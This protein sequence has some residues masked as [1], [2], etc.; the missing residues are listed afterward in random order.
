VPD[1]AFTDLL[2]ITA[3]AAGVPL[4]LGWAPRLR[5]PSVVLEIVAGI[6][7][8]PSVLGWVRVD[9]PVQILALVG[10][11][12][13]L[14][15]AGLEIDVRGI[16]GRLLRLAGAGYV[17]SAGLAVLVGFGFRSLG[18]T[19]SPLLLAVA[20]TATSLGLVVPVLKDAGKIGDP[21]GQATIAA[22]S[23]A[24]FTAIVL[25]TLLFSTSGG[26]AGTT[27]LFL[28]VFGVLVA[29]LAL[30]L[31]RVGRSMRLGEVLV[32]L[33]DSTA[34]IR[35]RLVVLLLAAFVALAER[36]GLET[37]LGAFLA[38]A[39]VGLVDRDSATH[40]RFRAKLDAIGYGFLIP[41]FFVSSGVG[42]DLRG[43]FE[44]PSALI[45]VPVFL[46][47]LLVVRGVP[48]M[49]FVRSL[50][51]RGATAVGLLQATSL[52]FL[53]TVA[54]IGTATGRLSGTNAAA[55]VCAGLLSVLIFP[56]VS[57][58]LLGRSGRPA[59]P[60]QWSAPAAEIPAARSV[61]V[62]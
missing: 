9:L 12:F 35:V 14:L 15:L 62:D 10:L 23:V 55:L 30:A 21:V 57:L 26:G 50:G 33:Q 25:L 34:E 19:P 51:R 36:F 49:L 60:E 52:P 18:W 31:G 28:G 4:A 59:I 24:D 11:A 3:V 43:L 56:A 53:V 48:A 41:V 44:H 20:L 45:R 37:I 5:V 1:V 13:L 61:A 47:A 17:V 27:A 40:P 7:L 42:L 38:G 16:S 46:V 32:R 29:V 54:Q 2:I 39:L 22:A 8:G 58:G 6:V